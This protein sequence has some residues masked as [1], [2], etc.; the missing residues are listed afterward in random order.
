MI[1]FRSKSASAY[2]DDSLKV[3]N[4]IS[5]VAASTIGRSKM[6]I[7]QTQADH[8]R[9]TITSISN[10]VA[11]ANDVRRIFDS[12]ALQIDEIIPIDRIVL[13]SLNSDKTGYFVEA[14]WG[15]SDE[16][17]RPGVTKKLVR[18]SH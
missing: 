17:L 6:T 1:N 9:A 10:S 7:A 16:Q 4:Q 3:A 15:P 18:Y 14:D 8:Q 13:S 5:T 12:I 11:Q 2:N